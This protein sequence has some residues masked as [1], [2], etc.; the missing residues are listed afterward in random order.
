LGDDLA[1][2]F[3]AVLFELE[4]EAE[5]GEDG[6]GLGLGGAEGFEREGF[7]EGDDGAGELFVVFVL[8]E[9]QRFG[10]VGEDVAAVGGTVVALVEAAKG[11]AAGLEFE[12]ALLAREGGALGGFGVG[13]VGAPVEELVAVGG[14]ELAEGAG[15][16]KGHT[17]YPVIFVRFRLFFVIVRGG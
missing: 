15:F 16:R 10:D 7:E 4:H 12:A 6:A 17:V 9:I 11:G 5:A 2:L 13:E 14:G 1:G 3:V 8:R